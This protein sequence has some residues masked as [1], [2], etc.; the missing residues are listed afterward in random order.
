VGPVRGVKPSG[1]IQASFCDVTHA[2]G[3]KRVARRAFAA[4]MLSAATSF[5]VASTASAPTS[6][7]PSYIRLGDSQVSGLAVHP[8]AHRCEV[9]TVPYTTSPQDTIEDVGFIEDQLQ[10]VGTGRMPLYSKWPRAIPLTAAPP[11]IRHHSIVGR[12]LSFPARSTGL[13]AS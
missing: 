13:A 11:S 12:S 4:G 10:I 1:L 2:P 5:L 6:S 8:Y 9:Y 3:S 7:P